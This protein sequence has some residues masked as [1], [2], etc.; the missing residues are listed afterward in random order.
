[1]TKPLTPPATIAFIGLGM[2]GRPMAARLVDAGF[3]LRVFDTSQKAV[4]DFVGAHPAALATASA[5][6]AAQGA[7]ALITMLPD[8]KIVRQAVLEGRDPAIE[9]LAAGALVLDMS[10]SNPVDT[11]K[12]ARD[13]AAKGVALLDAPVSG[14]VKRAIDGSL[15]IIVGGAEADL[16]RARPAIASMGKAIT[17]CGPVGAGHALKSLNNYLSAASLVAMCEALVVGEAFGLDPGTMVDV[18]NTSSGMSNSTQVKGRQQVV[19]RAFAAGFTTSLMA[20]D[21]RTAGDVAAHLKL[22]MPHLEQAVAYWSAANE[23]LGKGADHTEIF[24][25]AEMLAENKG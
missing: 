10:S 16:E 8:G 3:K 19:N 25:Y 24:R 2:M 9:G 17:L 13:L 11:Q 1:M 6:A 14:G 18:F 21:L 20:K 4:S 5:K 15:T 23:K 7:D 22:K 12:L